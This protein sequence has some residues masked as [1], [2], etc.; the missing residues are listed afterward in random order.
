LRICRVIDVSTSGYY[1]WRKSHISKRKAEDRKLLKDIQKHHELSYKIYGS[2]RIEQELRKNGIKTSKKRVARIMQ[3]NGIRSIIKRKYKSTTNSKHRLPIA[4]NILNQ[5]FSVSRLDSLWTS[6]IT[7]IWTKEGWLFLVII[8]EVKSRQIISWKVSNNLSKNFVIDATAIAIKIRKPKESLIFH[9]D[10]GVQ[11]A[12][13][14]MRKLLIKNNI[15]QSMSKRG[16]CYDNAIT[17]TFFHT[18][19]TEW[20]YQKTYETRKEAENSLFIYIELFYN[21]KRLHSSL[22]YN[23]PIDYEKKILHNK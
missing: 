9:S 22:N 1:K 16:D 21:R 6:D 3:E 14:E 12:S 19:K 4:E 23:S 20:V 8:L 11:Y 15:T 13:L 2:P 5:D 17:E 18:L 7:G 10:Q